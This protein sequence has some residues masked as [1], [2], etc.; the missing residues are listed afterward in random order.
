[1]PNTRKKVIKTVYKDD[2]SSE[3]EGHDFS[4]SGSEAVISDQESSDDEE[5]CHQ[6]SEDDFQSKQPKPKRQ[7]VKKP[8]T[9]F[10]KSFL[11]KINKQDVEFTENTP[12]FS[13]KDMTDADKLL[14]SI[15]NLSESGK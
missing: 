1:M 15:L 6:S 13:V 8:K 11:N 14:P 4:D 9:K 5:Q 3:N 7:N 12:L 2:E 10:T